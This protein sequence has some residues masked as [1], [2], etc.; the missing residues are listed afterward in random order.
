MTSA[1]FDRCRRV[2]VE[3]TTLAYCEEGEGEPVVFVHGTAGDM[4]TWEPQ[5]PAIGRSHRAIAYSRR[6][7]RPNEDIASDVDDPMPRHV[8]GLAAF[9]TAIGAPAAHLVGSSWGGFIGLLVAI[10]YPERV[11]SLVL[12]E[13]PVVPLFAETPPRPIELLRL[14]ATRPGTGM[15][16]LRFAAGALAPAQRA[17][18]K[19]QDEKAMHHFLDGVLGR[20]A[21][22]RLPE[23]ARQ[24]MRENLGAA[25]AQLLGAGFPPLEDE[26]VRGV[27]VPTLLVTGEHSPAF[28]LRL[29]DRLEELL[30][31]VDRVEIP[32]AS[33]VMHEDAP[34]AV[35]DAILGFVA[36]HA[37]SRELATDGGAA[38]GL[39]G[40]RA[41]V[42][43]D[44]S[45]EHR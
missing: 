11:R 26:E 31:L 34:A 22:A 35:N 36:R 6:Y 14:L 4:R 1:M 24:R 17:F 7:A 29:T 44:G 18:A 38:T 12:E 9:L 15:A 13:P 42:T 40:A 3:G 23:D 10:R 43:P 5:L 27:R 45:R 30:P 28:L 2:D 16:F 32:G 8:E 25:R 20:E 39:T 41:D 37:H 19:G 33:H 21:H